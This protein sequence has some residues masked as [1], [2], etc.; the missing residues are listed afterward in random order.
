MI[1]RLVDDGIFRDLET[2]KKEVVAF[3]KQLSSRLPARSVEM[4]ETTRMYDQHSKGV[5][6]GTVR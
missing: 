4:H 2:W 1:R 6:P 3:S 5:E